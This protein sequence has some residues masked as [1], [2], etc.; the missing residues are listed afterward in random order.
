M[1]DLIAEIGI[2]QLDGFIYEY[3]PV[4]LDWWDSEHKT[5]LEIELHQNEGITELQVIFCPEVEGIVE[6]TPVF[7]ATYIGEELEGVA[8]VADAVKVELLPDKEL[9]FSRER[10]AYIL[11][12]MV[13]ATEM[14]SKII[15]LIEER[16][17]WEIIDLNEG[18][19]EDDEEYIS[20]P[21]E[22]IGHFIAMMHMN[23]VRFKKANITSYIEMGIGMEGEEYFTELK[24]DAEL[25]L[26]NAY[27]E[28]YGVKDR[29]YQRI[30]KTILE[31]KA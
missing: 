1:K 8:L 24:A 9:A 27:K 2:D 12:S 5:S 21:G 26:P 18:E 20:Q 23:S 14:F 25:D 15:A 22:T 13:E 31:Y 6:R 4:L 29:I 28:D 30:R 7:M 10:E 19:E 16:E 11:P 3:K 17:P